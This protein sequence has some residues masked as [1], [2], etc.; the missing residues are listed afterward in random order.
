LARNS[1]LLV[2]LGALLWGTDSLFRRPLSRGLSPVTIVFL[3]HVILALVVLAVVVRGRTEL[4]LLGRREWA[5][6]L[7]IAVGGSVLATS[8]F[9]YAIKYGNPSVTVLLQKT[10]PLF[11][12]AL[13]R[14]VLNERPARRFWYWLAPALA[15]ASLLSI[16]GGRTGLHFDVE[17]PAPLAA[18]LGAAWL[19]GSCTVFG[20]FVVG[21]MSSVLLTS[22]RFVLALPVLALMYGLQPA[23]SQ[24]LPASASDVATL[25]GMALIPGLAALLLYYRGLRHTIASVAS[26]GEL[27]FP[28]TAVAT[29]WFFLDVR[30]SGTQ[31]LGAVLLLAAFVGLSRLGRPPGEAAARPARMV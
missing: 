30:L 18:A 28:V 26:L 14:V 11:A 25:V 12:I 1:I 21:R 23:E 6:L 15:G 10:Q 16:P 20:R 13:A 17:Q 7:V 3:E 2:I 31:L 9:T 29:N 4:R 8:L 27:A 24:T 5:A 19:W 22:L